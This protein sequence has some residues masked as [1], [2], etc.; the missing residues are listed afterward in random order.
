MGVVAAVVGAVGAIG[1]AMIAG[2]AAKKAQQGADNANKQNVADTNALNKQMFDESR[3]STGHAFLPTYTGTA[4]QQTFNDLYGIYQS[5]QSPAQREAAANQVLQSMQPSVQA[6]NQY[7]NDVYNGQ[8]LAATR[9]YYQP[10]WDSRTQ[11]AQAQSDAIQQAYARTR[12]Q[13]LA[14]NMKQGYYGGSSVQSR[15]AQANLLGAMQQAALVK[16]NAQMQNA[17]EGTQ[18][19]IADLANRQQLL[20]EPLTRAQSLIN[21]QAL[22]GQAA[23]TGYDQLAQRLGLFNIGTGQ[24]TA[25]NSPVVSPNIS[26][27]QLAGSAL[28]SLAGTLGAAYINKQQQQPIYINTTPS[29]GGVY[30]FGKAGSG[31]TGGNY[32][33]TPSANSTIKFGGYTGE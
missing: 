10:L 30:D 16:G 5:G 24:F 33:V 7:L 11:T 23:Y 1:G 19:G 14:T 28:S 22:P 4:E 29:T 17:T 3:G 9:G 25:Q 31:Y 26:S 8:N 13:D 32:D 21:Y 12:Q 15:E 2:N 20:N 18:L 27:G 6:G